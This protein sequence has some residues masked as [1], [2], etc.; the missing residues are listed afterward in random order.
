MALPPKIIEF[1]SAKYGAPIRYPS[2]CEK[3]AIDIREKLNENIGVTTLK[4]L[5]GFVHDVMQPRLITLDILAHYAGFEDYDQ[6][7]NSAIDAG[8]SDFENNSDIKPS[9]LKPGQ[10]LYFEYRPDRKVTLEYLGDET[11]RVVESPKG[12]LRPNDILS[13][14]SLALNL[15]LIVN[16]VERNGLDLGRYIAGKISGL[17]AIVLI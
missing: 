4:R 12:S 13:I 11:F 6:M 15:P 3:L 10:R 14:N 1:I 9:S 8:D 7:L 17:T 2:D 16:S 5:F